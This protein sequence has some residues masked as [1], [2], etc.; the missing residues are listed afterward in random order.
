MPD[1]TPALDT[2]AVLELDGYLKP[3]IPNIVHR[4]DLFRK[5]K[6]SI[7]EHEG[8][9]DAFTKGYLKFGLNTTEKNE[10]VYREWAPNAVEAYLIGEFSQ[11]EPLFFWLD[12]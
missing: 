11:S 6:D 7:E 1:R 3:D 2:E 9:Y 5:W 8:G 4:Y 10:V 12:I